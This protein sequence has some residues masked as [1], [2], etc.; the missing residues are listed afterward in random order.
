MVDCCEATAKRAGVGNTPTI[1]LASMQ[2][3]NSLGNSLS[4]MWDDNIVG[5]HGRWSMG[6]RLSSQLGWGVFGITRNGR[7]TDGGMECHQ[8]S[9]RF[10]SDAVDAGWRHDYGLGTCLGRVAGSNCLEPIREP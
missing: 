4:G 9:R 7:W 2:Y 8:R 1:G 6:G 10:E 3:A 5:T